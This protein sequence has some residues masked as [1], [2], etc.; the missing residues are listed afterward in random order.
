MS[1][2]ELN[3]PMN[4]WCEHAAHKKGCK[5]YT[6]RPEAC[7]AYNCVWLMT[8]APLELRPDK[9]HGVMTNNHAGDQIAI[10]ED[11]GYPGFASHALSRV[12]DAFI[13]KPGCYVVVVTG[14]QRRLIAAPELAKRLMA[15]A[16]A[17]DAVPSV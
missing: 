5:V 2:R 4:V 14:D 11:A 8:N 13:A 12:I 1:V 16:N 15:R 10:H 6:V 3:K 17:P 7:R 9:I